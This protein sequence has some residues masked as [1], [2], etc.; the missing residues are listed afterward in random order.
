MASGEPRQSSRPFEDLWPLTTWP[1]VPTRV[2]AATDDRFFPVAFQ[3]RLAQERLGLVAD[4][5]PGGHLVALSRPRE[6][7]DR[8]VAY[9]ESTMTAGSDS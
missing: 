3:R 9:L 5:M 2:L 6:L 7:A 4:E 8:L 1:G